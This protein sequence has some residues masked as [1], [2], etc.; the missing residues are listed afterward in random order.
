M[1]LLR[2][3]IGGGS[4]V[5]LTGLPFWFIVIT[6]YLYVEWNLVKFGALFG[7]VGTYSLAARFGGPIFFFEIW[8][9]A[10]I[11]NLPTVT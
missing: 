1:L 5:E 10:L 9:R 8:F 4:G 11:G 7:Y 6:M 3:C 2:C